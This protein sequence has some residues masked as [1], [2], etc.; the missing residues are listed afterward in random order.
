MDGRRPSLR[1]L[2]A[3]R[4][5]ELRVGD[6]EGRNRERG[7][8]KVS[9]DILVIV[10]SACYCRSCL[11][12]SVAWTVSGRLGA[13]EEDPE[14]FPSSEGFF[15]FLEVYLFKA[16]AATGNLLMTKVDNR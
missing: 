13:R 4:L 6:V 2:S 11:G 14:A 16:T 8:V 10:A 7:D 9:T 3:K 5:D 12:R 15:S 1:R